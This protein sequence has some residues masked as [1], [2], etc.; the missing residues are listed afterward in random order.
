M[1]SFVE[2]SCC[3]FSQAQNIIHKRDTWVFVKSQL[4]FGSNQALWEEGPDCADDGEYNGYDHDGGGEYP[5]S[6]GELVAEKLEVK[7][8]GQTNGVRNVR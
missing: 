6:N 4:C 7:G 8:E 2:P 5:F 3:A 1:Q